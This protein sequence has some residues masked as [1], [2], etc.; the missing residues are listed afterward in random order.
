ME[1]KKVNLSNK[2]VEVHEMLA[3]EFDKIISIENATDRIASIVKSSCNFTDEDY[4]KLTIKD[5]SLIM[6][7]INELNGWLGETDFTQKEN[8]E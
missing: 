5:R 1:T 6:N 3:I 7:A 8:A 4:S 2:E